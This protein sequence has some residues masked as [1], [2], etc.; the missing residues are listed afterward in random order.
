[1]IDIFFG[2]NAIWFSAVALAGTGIFAL[3]LL[4]MIV[5]IGDVDGGD[6]ELAADGDTSLGL[7]S[8]NGMAGIM[9]GFGY[10]ALI[11]YRSF[12]WGFLPSIGV[13]VVS[14]IGVGSII[15]MIFRS[16]SRLE[17]SGTVDATG[18]VGNSAAV[19]TAIPENPNER[20]R[21]RVIIDGRMRYYPARSE[22]GS[23][24]RG[25]QVRI[26]AM[27]DDRTVVVESM[28][29]SEANE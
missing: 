21:V 14:G 25:A 24:P 8:L 16:M 28:T 9:M 11:S 19:Y 10:G 12:E 20:G 29:A 17:S 7:L 13:G 18:A 15:V 3:R 23:Y 27:D 1:M 5:G 26:K 2:D 22:S 6:V 4:L